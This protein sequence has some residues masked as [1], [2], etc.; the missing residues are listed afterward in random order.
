M[1]YCSKKH[2]GED[3]HLT[4]S[5]EVGVI[6]CG[7]RVWQDSQSKASIPSGWCEVEREVVVKGLGFEA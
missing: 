7:A 2:Y 5:T 3:M 6:G 1:T 4:R